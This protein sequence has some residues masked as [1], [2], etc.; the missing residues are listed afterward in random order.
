MRSLKSEEVANELIQR[1]RNSNLQHGDTLVGERSLAEEFEISRGTVRSS[2]KMLVNRNW[3][4][5]VQG[6][7]YVIQKIPE[8]PSHRTMNIAGI[9]VKELDNSKAIDLFTAASSVAEE[10]GYHLFLSGA[11]VDERCQA[12][13]IARI[14]DT[15]PDGIMIVPV[16]SEKN[17]MMTLGNYEL[18]RTVRRSGIPL[19]LINRPFPE[20]DLPCVVND[21]AMGGEMAADYFI[22]LGVTRVARLDGRR[23]YISELRNRAFEGKCREAGIEVIKIPDPF[24]D[25]EPDLPGRRLERRRQFKQMMLKD[26]IEG[27]FFGKPPILEALILDFEDTGIHLLCY[28]CVDYLSVRGSFASVI[29]PQQEIAERG[30]ERLLR[31]IKGNDDEPLQEKIPPQIVRYQAI[32][33]I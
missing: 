25:M 9:W 17:D 19:M 20:N 12:A 3:L 2:L 33:R 32:E 23:Y 29:R 27:I 15:R 4:K 22:G 28:D 31:Q 11:A 13:K 26:K 1:I 7:G 8:A 14:L 24:A 10:H 21:D 16:Y 6:K 18:I 5:P 30:M